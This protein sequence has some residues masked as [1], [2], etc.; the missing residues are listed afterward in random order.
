M[1][2]VV[3]DDDALIR[4]AITLCV[5]VHSTLSCCL[6]S[7]LPVFHFHFFLL[8]F[9]SLSFWLSLLSQTKKSGSTAFSVFV[10]SGNQDRARHTDRDTDRRGVDGR[11]PEREREGQRERE[12]KRKG[13]H[14]MLNEAQQVAL[15]MAMG[16]S[17]HSNQNDMRRLYAYA[18]ISIPISLLHRDESWTMNDERVSNVNVM[19]IHRGCMYI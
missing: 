4:Y 2:F 19:R 12:G 9:R 13:E 7:H 5:L 16:G 8:W 11:Q 6:F 10:L 3:H 1:F 18:S 15:I 17:S 14:K